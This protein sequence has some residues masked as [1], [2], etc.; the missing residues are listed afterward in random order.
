LK[1]RYF[2][3][4]IFTIFSILFSDYIFEIQEIRKDFIALS[5]KLEKEDLVVS[6]S[7]WNSF[8]DKKEIFYNNNYYDISSYKIVNDKVH[9]KVF[10][11]TFE[12]FFKTI[13]KNLS[14]KNKFKN[15]KTF[16]LFYLH[17]K[18]IQTII[19]NNYYQKN[20][21]YYLLMHP[22]YITLIFRPPIFN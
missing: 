21:Y 3:L 2:I 20:S 9:I 13:Q 1:K 22:S 12:I 14:L 16:D 19:A 7:S 17:S 4:F 15:K 11:D 6:K 5:K 10:H 18:I 8:L